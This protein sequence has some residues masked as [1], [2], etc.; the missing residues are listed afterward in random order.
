MSEGP[1]TGQPEDGDESPP[2]RFMCADHV[3]ARPRF[4]PQRNTMEPVSSSVPEASDGH[5]D[6]RVAS[7]PPVSTPPRGGRRRHRPGDHAA[8]GGVRGLLGYVGHAEVLR[9][10][11]DAGTL[12]VVL[13]VAVHV[14]AVLDD[15]DVRRAGRPAR[16]ELVRGEGPVVV[17]GARRVGDGH[18]VDG[19]PA[20]GRC[21]AFGGQCHEDVA[22]LAGRLLV[23]QQAVT[24]GVGSPSWDT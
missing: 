17:D 16:P 7:P 18:P 14:D 4:M 2:R 15:V 24:V 21:V 9:E 1:A 10:R 20:L 11:R 6:R 13:A 8:A 12:D 23:G 3:R 22:V 19:Q 5:I